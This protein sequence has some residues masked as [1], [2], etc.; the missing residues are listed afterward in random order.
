MYLPIN[1]YVV[2]E[3][4]QNK[5]EENLVKYLIAI[6]IEF[7]VQKASNVEIDFSFCFVQLTSFLRLFFFLFLHRAKLSM[8]LNAKSIK[9]HHKVFLKIFPTNIS[10]FFSKKDEMFSSKNITHMKTAE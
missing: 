9:V 7:P 5:K 8:I 1:N 4:K 10:S 6:I 2:K 3:Q